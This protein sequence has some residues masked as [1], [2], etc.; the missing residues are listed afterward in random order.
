MNTFIR[1]Q[2]VLREAAHHA[3]YA[4][5]KVDVRKLFEGSAQFSIFRIPRKVL[6]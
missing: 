3:I 1:K 5:L 2:F 6:N 4:E